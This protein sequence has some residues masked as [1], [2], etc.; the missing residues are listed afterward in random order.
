MKTTRVFA[1]NN[2]IEESEPVRVCAAYTKNVPDIRHEEET[3]PLAL[4][5]R[6]VA[7][8]EAAIR[9][10]GYTILADPETGAIKLERTPVEEHGWCGPDPLV[11][12]GGWMEQ[13]IRE[14]TVKE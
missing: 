12:E 10:E 13:R 11:E 3:E 5:D 9:A 6:H 2:A 8:L 14:A 7:A 4:T 1:A